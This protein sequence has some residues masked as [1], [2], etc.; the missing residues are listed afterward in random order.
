MTAALGFNGFGGNR[1][2]RSHAG[3]PALPGRDSLSSL[4]SLARR[5]NSF[6]PHARQGVEVVQV[7]E[8]AMLVGGYLCFA[9][10]RSE[11]MLNSMCSPMIRKPWK[12]L[13][14][15]KRSALGGRNFRAP[16]APP[17]SPMHG[18]FCLR[19]GGRDSSMSPTML[20]CQS[21]WTHLQ[22]YGGGVT[23]F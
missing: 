5:V 6:N 13:R 22:S 9:Q 10:A 15:Y 18:K 2:H 12:G 3:T 14:P 20:Y 16:P 4:A 23:N 19:C 11:G 7:I 8:Q 21:C 17:T 1:L